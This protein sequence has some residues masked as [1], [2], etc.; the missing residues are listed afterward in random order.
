MK[1]S[2]DVCIGSVFFWLFGYS[3]AFGESRANGFIGSTEG[4]YGAKDFDKYNSYL[5]F[6]N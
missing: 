2:M 1:N 6:M 3:F 5:H 4:L